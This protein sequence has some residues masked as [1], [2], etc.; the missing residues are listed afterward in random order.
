MAFVNK[1]YRGAVP[2]ADLDPNLLRR[3]VRPLRYKIADF[4][5]NYSGHVLVALAI[6]ALCIPFTDLPQVSDWIG[7]LG[8]VFFLYARKKV[9]TYTF[10]RPLDEGMTKKEQDQAGIMFLGNEQVDGTGVWFS[11]DDLKTHALIFGSTGSGKTRTLLSL[12]YQ[13]LVFGS[14][15]I[16]VDGKADNSVAWLLY[17][18]CRRLGREDDFLVINYLTGGEKPKNGEISLN[19]L[20]NTTNPF[21]VGNSEQ[22]RS[23]IVG[24]M[25]GGDSG[26]MWAGRASAM[27]GGLLK[28]LVH[29]RD[30]GEINLDIAKIREYLNL[31]KVAELSLRND[32]PKAAIEPIQKFLI[33]LPGYSEEE[34]IVGS[35]QAKAY[36]QFSYL[37]M[38][39][40][41]VMSNLSDTYGHIF[42]AERGEVDFK[43]VVFNRR[44][45][46]V[47]LPALEVDPDA[48]AGLG[49]MVV[50][51]VR[52]ALGPALGNKLE[53]TRTEVIE[54]KPTNSKVPF[55][56][57]LDEYGYY[58]VK[59]FAVVAAQARS[60]GVSVIFAGQDY[61]SFKKGDEIEAQATV[62]N[63]NI[64][65]VMK[66]EDAKETYDVMKTRAGQAEQIVSGGFEGG[67]AMG[68]YRDSLSARS[69]KVDRLAIE[70]LV[71]QDPGEGYVIFRDK[72]RPIKMFYVDPVEVPEA[73]L[74]KFLMVN[75][76]KAETLKKMTAGVERLEAR[77]GIGKHVQTV[78]AA[79]GDLGIEGFVGDFHALRERNEGMLES[80]IASIGLLEVKDQQT[81][82]TF[83]RRMRN[84]QRQAKLEEQAEREAER[85]QF[86]DEFEAHR[87]PLP[88]NMPAFDS[89]EALE[90]E[91]SEEGYIGDPEPGQS[92]DTENLSP[93]VELP[94]EDAR[95]KPSLPSMDFLDEVESATTMGAADIDWEADSIELDPEAVFGAAVREQNTTEAH[96]STD[97]DGPREQIEEIAEKMSDSSDTDALFNRLL[98]KI[99]GEGKGAYPQNKI[100]KPRSVA[101]ILQL[102]ENVARFTGKD[103]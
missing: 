71:D 58:A 102:V 36:E 84:D 35:I 14:G 52:A 40:S 1:N 41:E 30:Q 43:D 100:E 70:D 103:S 61:P 98:S 79:T 39:L 69:E 75:P 29:M 77:F 4:V 88:E 57:V 5:A 50:A 64:K 94:M 49:R 37:S 56:I 96:P 48:L 6:L 101:D 27:M 93:R 2:N 89:N 54:T 46:F 24:L 7:A 28:A 83:V 9:R 18:I 34:A 44:V 95:E 78:E 22:L 10:R 86:L 65:V 21:A 76:P 87:T 3:D 32:I 63:T 11:A 55:M 66:L 26:D 45:L 33:E 16:Y 74:N 80:A 38:Q 62:A 13:A 17:S 72:V 59:G 31:D 90:E 23:L 20:S 97:R 99:K 25:R 19:R 73:E 51:A 92:V 12:T 60:L 82:K 91:W 8:I 53:G 67:A 68:G 42:A 81:D 15:L 85:Q 47:M